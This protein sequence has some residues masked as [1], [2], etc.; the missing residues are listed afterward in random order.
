LLGSSVT[1]N[2]HGRSSGFEMTIDTQYGDVANDDGISVF[3]VT[4]PGQPRYA[5]IQLTDHEVYYEDDDEDENDD[6]DMNKILN[7]SDYMHRY[8]K[9]FPG[10]DSAALIQ[11]L[12]NL[13]QSMLL[14]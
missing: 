3:D 8:R 13:P 4:V 12:D 5:M 6:D 14:R 10:P 11:G 1:P 2:E 7:A 9:D